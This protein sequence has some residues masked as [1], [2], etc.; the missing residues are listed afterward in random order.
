MARTVTAKSFRVVDRHRTRPA[1]GLTLEVDPRLPAS[2]SGR[3]V[4]HCD[5]PGRYIGPAHQHSSPHE[6]ACMAGRVTWPTD[7][8]PTAPSSGIGWS[9][10]NCSRSP[11][12][13]DIR[14]RLESG[15]V[16]GVLSPAL[17][18]LVP[19]TDLVELSGPEWELP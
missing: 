11:V 16:V 10:A 14:I 3:V 12:G 4:Y 9:R 7:H 19:D 6:I 15:G 17:T 2:A 1:D 8:G 13:R 18:W 5:G